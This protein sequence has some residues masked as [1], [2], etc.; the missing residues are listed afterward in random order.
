MQIFMMERI[1]RIID[2]RFC[3]PGTG[4]VTLILAVLILAAVSAISFSVGTLV[5]REL[6]SS[7]Q[8]SQSE[9]VI[10]SAEAGAETAL[11]FRM[12]KLAD[13]Y[14]SSCPSSDQ[15]TLSNGSTYSV[16]NDYYDN[17][18][19]FETHSSDPEVVLLIDPSDPNNVAAGYSSLT[20]NATSSS[21]G[22]IAQLIVE[23]YDL[24]AT[25]TIAAWGTIS[26]PGSTTLDLDPQKSYAVFLRP[27]SS[28]SVSGS[29]TGNSGT[30]GIPSKTPTITS[31][32]SNSALVRKLKIFLNP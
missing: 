21:P 4:G 24:S 27:A 23:A 18:Y 29:M 1:K 19:I 26:I 9:P 14:V 30:K 28:G 16:C 2:R 31:A 20:I 17:P 8:L 25:S 13:Q 32:G 6:K 3:N 22:V 5:L 10:V 12:R 11:F 7:R 15:G